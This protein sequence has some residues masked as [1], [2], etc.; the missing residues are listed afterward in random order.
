MNGEEWKRYRIDSLGLLVFSQD[1]HG[2]G[3]DGQIIDFP[4][5]NMTP[6]EALASARAASEISNS[7]FDSAV[8]Q[9]FIKL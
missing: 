3:S 7:F 4:T 5:K 6:G 2:I 1:T 8:A 9:G